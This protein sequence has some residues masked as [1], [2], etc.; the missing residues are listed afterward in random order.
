MSIKILTH[1]ELTSSHAHYVARQIPFAFTDHR[2]GSKVNIVRTSGSYFKSDKDERWSLS[3][4]RRVSKAPKTTIKEL[5]KI[6][7]SLNE[8]AEEISPV[9]QEQIDLGIAKLKKRQS[10]DKLS[11]ED[12]NHLYNGL[13]EKSTEIR[14]QI[15]DLQA[16][17]SQNDSDRSLISQAI[18]RKEF[19][20]FKVNVHFFEVP[21]SFEIM[22][23]IYNSDRLDG[24]G[25][26]FE[27]AKVFIRKIEGNNFH[28]SVYPNPL[29]VLV[30]SHLYLIVKRKK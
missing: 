16:Q 5:V 25:K 12:L 30:A 10:F 14:K 28:F 17:I 15:A 8:P 13:G 3:D 20:I 29:R 19:E 23:S 26:P 6:T 22:Q 2:D 4:I 21:Q 27:S 18:D 24:K 9:V 1:E 7:K 11:V